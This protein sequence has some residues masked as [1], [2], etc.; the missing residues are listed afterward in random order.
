MTQFKRRGLF[1]LG[2]G[3]AAVLA[4]G[5]AIT[6]GAAAAGEPAPAGTSGM[7]LRWWGNNSWEIRLPG[8]KT[9]LIDPWLTRYHTGTYSKAGA[10]PE[11]P[12]SVDTALIDHYV[13]SGELRA[14][15][16]L[17]THGHYD[18]LS[19]VPYLAE[20]TGATVLGTETH[21]NLLAALGA[22]EGQLALATGGE[23][24]TF[25][26]YTIR[27]LR[28]L[29]SATGARAQ[30]P[31]PGTRPGF[32]GAKLPKPTV[33]R[34]LVEGGT[35]AYLVSGGGASV[36]DFGGSNYVESELAGLRP[37]VVLLPAGGGKIHDYVAR[38]LG[39][40]GGPRFVLPTHWDDF[41]YPLTEP[42]RDWGGLETLR[43]AVAKASPASE[44]VV[45]DHLD[46]F[47]P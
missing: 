42:A 16:I 5:G 35:L 33:I 30:V 32:G 34:E 47:R 45:V 17:V 19:D 4:A 40:V 46:T 39:A 7:T 21:L 26:G 43:A 3:A 9:V 8:G 20:K 28:S 29:H 24:L 23:Y 25:D 38:L 1:G 11:T 27:V 12:I 2:A 6:A 41:D 14:D 37:D 31:F 36:L 18:H 44:F 13:D 22:P 10:D 15:H